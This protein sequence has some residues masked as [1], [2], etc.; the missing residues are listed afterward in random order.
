[1]TKVIN[2]EKMRVSRMIDNFYLTLRNEV[3]EEEEFIIALIFKAYD[4]LKLPK[5]YWGN[6]TG[7]DDCIIVN[8]GPDACRYIEFRSDICY[9]S[10]SFDGVPYDFEVPIENLQLIE[11]EN[12]VLILTPEMRRYIYDRQD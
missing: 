6:F 9:F 12:R 5:E 11:S 1:M 4:G 7:L 10:L 3:S 2:M 8:I